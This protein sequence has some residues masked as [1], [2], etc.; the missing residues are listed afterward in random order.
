MIEFWRLPL[1]FYT[2]E[3]DEQ[4]RALAE[5]TVAA[6]PIYEKRKPC[7]MPW[8]QQLQ[9]V[10]WI[11]VGLG[12]PLAI[13]PVSIFLSFRSWRALTFWL[14]ALLL[15]A[16]HPLAPYSMESRRRR[17]GLLLARYFSFVVVVDK[18]LKYEQL[19]CTPEVDKVEKQ[20]G[21]PWPIITLACPHGVLNFGAIC[22]V[23]FERWLIGMEQYTAGA[24]AV[25]YTPGLRHFTQGLWVI[26]ADRKSL[27][28]C[29]QE[30]PT[31][32]RQ[33]GGCVG[34]VPDG[35]AGIFHSK[36]GTDI[37]HLG[38]KR[39][40]MRIALEEGACVGAGWFSGTTDCFT[41]VQ[42]PLGIM[43][44]V[45]RK[46]GLSLFLFYGRWGL[47][48]PRRSP[49]SCIMCTTILEK[50]DSPTTEQVEEAH[51]KVYGGMVDKFHRLK[52]YVG[53]SD[54]TLVLT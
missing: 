49:T 38:K 6:E 26:S 44:S 13:V 30:R 14:A 29:L 9:V 19:Y 12:L 21:I 37:L 39:G 10:L 33:R 52:S 16:L 32:K 54:R 45:S 50:N 2:L 48:I 47:P 23:N 31:E 3:L 46:L 34:V 20:L 35:I 51:Q 53:L 7:S 28:R 1:N 25:K 27:K 18:K 41:I 36:P 22:W 11:S 40:L 4:W 15:L 5:V 17:M 24:N 43:R 42:D 8:T